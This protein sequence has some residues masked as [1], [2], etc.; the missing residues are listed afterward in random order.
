MA[1]RLINNVSGFTRISSALWSVSVPCYVCVGLHVKASS[2]LRT[3]YLGIC[4]FDD[5]KGKSSDLGL[6][7][8][9]TESNQIL[10]MEFI[11]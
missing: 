10:G 11:Y 2:A 1:A 9:S 4:Y 6:R 7:L 5:R 8:T 3:D